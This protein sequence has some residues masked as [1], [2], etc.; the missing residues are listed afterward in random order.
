MR[1]RSRSSRRWMRRRR[2]RRSRSSRRRRLE[3]ESLRLA[4]G[5]GS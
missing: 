1:W 2:R 3:F 5:L 4:G